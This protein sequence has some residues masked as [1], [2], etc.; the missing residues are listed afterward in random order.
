LLTNAGYEATREIRKVEIAR[1]AEQHTLQSSSPKVPAPNEV[2]R[3]PPPG[4]PVLIPPTPVIQSRTK[5]FALTGLA[6]PDDKR[7][8]FGSGV[9]G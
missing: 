5:I 6:T 9:D 2:P 7:K 1:R 3:I 8:A 4:K